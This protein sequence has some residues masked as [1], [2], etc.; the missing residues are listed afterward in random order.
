MTLKRVKQIQITNFMNNY[1]F[2]RYLGEQTQ[3]CYVDI[4]E[5]K[6]KKKLL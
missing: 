3:N 1:D 4:L 5:K 2:L 6:F